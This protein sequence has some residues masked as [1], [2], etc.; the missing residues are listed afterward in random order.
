[1]TD[2]YIHFI[3]PHCGLSGNAPVRGKL[4]IAALHA[5]VRIFRVLEFLAAVLMFGA[6]AIF[7]LKMSRAKQKPTKSRRSQ[8]RKKRTF[9]SKYTVDGTGRLRKL[10]QTPEHEHAKLR[11]KQ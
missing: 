4:V 2:I 1:M 5:L 11:Y 7:T 10:G 8:A 6:A 3:C 9:V